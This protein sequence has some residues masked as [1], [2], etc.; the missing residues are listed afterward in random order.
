MIAER[1]D[2][3]VPILPMVPRRTGPHFSSWW[4]ASASALCACIAAT[5]FLLSSVERHAI[6]YDLD[7]SCAGI[8]ATSSRGACTRDSVSVVDRP[9]PD[10][11]TIA[12]PDT[13]Q[14]N[15]HLVG[16]GADLLWAAAAAAGAPL[17][18]I[19]DDDG[20]IVLLGSSDGTLEAETAY[21]PDWLNHELFTW[22]LVSLPF[23][24]IA[25]FG[26]LALRAIWPEAAN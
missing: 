26:V 25:S 21:N 23:I 2:A 18:A 8:G 5:F 16:G 15:V 13:S 11:L 19:V 17:T 10:Y 9:A 14:Y 3:G 1:V 22:L 24:G 4:V 12:M 6:A 20:H 7:M